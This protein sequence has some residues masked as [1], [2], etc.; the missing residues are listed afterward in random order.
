MPVRTPM[1]MSNVALSRGWS[2]LGNQ[3]AAISDSPRAS[4]PS[5]VRIQALRGAPHPAVVTAACEGRPA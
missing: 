4:A 5:G 3:V 1:E 2:L